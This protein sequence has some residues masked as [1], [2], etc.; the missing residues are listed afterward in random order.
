MSTLKT[1]PSK[2]SNHKTDDLLTDENKSCGESTC[3]EIDSIKT[4][5]IF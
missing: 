2:Q 3:S 5:N 1:V 4:E